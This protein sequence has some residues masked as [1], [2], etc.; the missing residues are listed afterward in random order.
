MDTGGLSTPSWRGVFDADVSEEADLDDDEVVEEGERHAAGDHASSH[1]HLFQDRFLFSS[2]SPA[3]PPPPPSS[4][5]SMLISPAAGVSAFS[6]LAAWGRSVTFDASVEDLPSTPAA[7]AP[8]PTPLRK[9]VSVSRRSDGYHRVKGGGA[10]GRRRVG[11][12][13]S[14]AGSVTPTGGGARLE[15]ERAGPS[16]VSGKVVDRRGEKASRPRFTA[17]GG[18][19]PRRREVALTKSVVSGWVC[20]WVK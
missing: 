11:T 1:R 5:A 16:R 9:N 18:V 19:I 12:A 15:T 13:K 10:E 14:S 6:G 4:L 20:G 17:S 7:A 2:S 8:K 3:P